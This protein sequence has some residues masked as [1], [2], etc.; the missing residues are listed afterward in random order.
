MYPVIAV[1]PLV[2]GHPALS[3][4]TGG[5]P[6]ADT[7]VQANQNQ[8]QVE[9]EAETPVHGNALRKVGKAE[10]ARGILSGEEPYVAGI[11]EQGPFQL[12]NEREAILY[13]GFYL[14]V[15]NLAGNGKTIGS[16]GGAGAQGA[17][18]PAPHGHGAAGVKVLLY[19]R[20]RG[21]AIGKGGSALPVQ[22]Q[23]LPVF[24]AE[25]ENLAQVQVKT[26][27]LRIRR[28]PN[29]ILLVFLRKQALEQAQHIAGHIHG[30]PGIVVR[31][32]RDG[33]GIGGIVK[34]GT[35]AQVKLILVCHKHKGIGQEEPLHELFVHVVQVRHVEPERRKL[36]IQ[37]VADTSVV[38]EG[39]GNHRAAEFRP[40]LVGKGRRDVC[41]GNV[42][43]FENAVGKADKLG[44]TQRGGH[45]QFRG[46]GLG[47]GLELE[48]AGE[49]QVELLSPVEDIPVV[50]IELRRHAH[51]AGGV[52]GSLQIELEA[53]QAGR[54]QG[55]VAVNRGVRDGIQLNVHARE[56][57]HGRK[58]AVVGV[59]LLLAVKLPRAQD[60]QVLQGGGAD[61]R[62]FRMGD[63]HLPQLELPVHPG[64]FRAVPQGIIPDGLFEPDLPV[65]REGI[66]L[67]DIKRLGEAEVT[68]I[69]EI[70]RRALRLL[71]QRRL[72]EEVPGGQGAVGKVLREFLREASV[73]RYF[74][75]YFADFVAFAKLYRI[76][77]ISFLLLYVHLAL[78]L[79]P[80][81]TDVLQVILQVGHPLAH[82][83]GVIDDGLG[84][85]LP[86]KA[87]EGRR[88]VPAPV[89]HGQQ[90]VH[91]Q[92]IGIG[93]MADIRPQGRYLERG[94]IGHNGVLSQQV[95]PFRERACGAAGRKTRSK[96]KDKY[97]F[98][99]V[100][101]HKCNTFCVYLHD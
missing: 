101:S 39:G 3:L 18:L 84:A 99:G 57:A 7:H 44:E 31:G 58:T 33:G 48:I 56:H 30:Q 100:H 54:A 43:A 91:P 80:V 62:F 45:V 46:I 23:R 82:F 25:A 74:V 36:V 51:Q 69:P 85:Y 19:R 29:Q 35:H 16:V 41:P 81:K 52:H 96:Q 94:V 38:R 55:D 76:C 92:N 88:A 86:Q 97:D 89:V 75:F 87:P 20:R 90:R 4:G 2:G 14:E 64:R 8:V 15:A 47:P 42:G 24:L 17:G 59:N 66:G 78:H 32:L 60:I 50:V 1:Q 6:E 71:L 79:R 68:E 34:H 26:D 63:A 40:I 5:V 11:H 12:G 73:L 61:F 93:F 10:L 37:F 95:L 65:L 28:L 70:G 21:I 27:I 22:G 49:P 53:L 72:R 9:P 67:E 77:Y 13:V 83:L 98:P